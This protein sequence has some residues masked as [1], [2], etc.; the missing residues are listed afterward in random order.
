MGSILS[1]HDCLE[2]KY[3]IV[4]VLLIGEINTVMEITRRGPTMSL[5]VGN[6][7]GIA[8]FPSK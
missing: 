4:H 3:L 8:L 6:R 5:M 7:N 2:M 1:H